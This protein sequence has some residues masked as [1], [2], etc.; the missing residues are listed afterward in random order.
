MRKV[1]KYKLSDDYIYIY[2]RARARTNTYKYFL[3]TKRNCPTEHIPR[4][5]EGLHTM[6]K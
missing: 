6:H 5:T 2:T 4:Q 1:I 3:R